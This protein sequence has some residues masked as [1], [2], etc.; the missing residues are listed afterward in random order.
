MKGR[1]GIK[2]LLRIQVFENVGTNC[3]LVLEI[4][5]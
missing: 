1:K 5:G 2:T 3:Y 4:Y